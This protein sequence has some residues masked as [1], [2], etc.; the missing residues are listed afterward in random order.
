MLE[1]FRG[2]AAE[3]GIEGA[4]VLGQWPDVAQ[5]VAAADVVVCGHVF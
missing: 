2:A 5:D 3:A 4:T 1:S